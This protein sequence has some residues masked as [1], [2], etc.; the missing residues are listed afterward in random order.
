M[1]S[2]SSAAALV[3]LLTIP[4]TALAQAP[5]AAPPGEPPVKPIV[6]PLPDVVASVNGEK[7]S[8]D[9]LEAA[10]TQFQARVRQAIPNDQR[11]RVVRGVLD[12]LIAYRLLKQESS[13]RKVAIPDADIDS[14]VAELKSQFASEDAFVQA[15]GEQKL[16]VE[17]L[18]ANIR[19]GMQIDRLVAAE[20]DSKIAVTAQQVDAFYAANPKEFTHGERVRASH[21]L[22]RVA[23]DADPAAKEQARAK[24]TDVLKQARAG[25]DFVALAKQYSEDPG[26]GPNGGDL[27]FFERGQMVPTFD[28]AAFALM[29]KEISEIVETPFGLHIILVAEKQ[30]AGTIP[31]TAVRSQIEEFLQGRS[32]E[33]QAQVFIASLRA[34][35]KVEIFI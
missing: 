14:R 33:E 26:S 20:I 32:R 25:G 17:S 28:A 18:R 11:D 1:T 10:M 5:P 6:E 27:G 35:G 4:A 19:E 23:P 34:K 29:P 21:I 15:L 30:A 9:D 24:M 12:Q 8:K 31:L 22:I 13:T 16:T 2:F 3:L 7:I